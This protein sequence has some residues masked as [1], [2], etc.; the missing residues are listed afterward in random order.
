VSNWQR[1]QAATGVVEIPTIP[2]EP[3]AFASGMRRI[4]GSK[5]KQCLL[6]F[7]ATSARR[8]LITLIV[9]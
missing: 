3:L 7:A 6:N 5:M 9:N 1:L 8:W 4:Q 2:Y